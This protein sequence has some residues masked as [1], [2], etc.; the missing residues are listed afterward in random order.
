[1]WQAA[2]EQEGYDVKRVIVTAAI[3]LLA[4]A[5]V[6]VAVA[7]GCG[8]SF[9][10]KVTIITRNVIGA[11][12]VD[13]WGEDPPEG[14]ALHSTHGFLLTPLP[15]VELAFAERRHERLIT[16]YMFGL[17]TGWPLRSLAGVVWSRAYQDSIYKA[18]L[19]TRWDQNPSLW[20]VY[21][22]LWPGFAVNTLFYAT[23]L[24]TLW[25][26]TRVGYFYAFR[27][28]IRVRRGLCPACAY[29]MGK[30]D[31]CTECGIPLAPQRIWQ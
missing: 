2:A 13:W 30:S 27:R 16:E 5:M 26:L 4:G 31:V 1:M 20:L 8:L 7:W 24:A 17:R 6:N 23:I 22:P 11:S 10:L 14:F 15:G 29:P 18:A 19:P 12:P 3:F 21:R 25:L 28:V 9:N